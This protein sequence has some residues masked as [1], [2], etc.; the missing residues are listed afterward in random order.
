MRL[1]EATYSMSHQLLCN[2]SL[3]IKSWPQAYQTWD[4]CRIENLPSNSIFKPQP[5]ST[6]V[7]VYNIDGA[8]QKIKVIVGHLCGYK[9]ESK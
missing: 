1:T 2:C 7:T 5:A 6:V 8:K 4:Q 9:E 3:D